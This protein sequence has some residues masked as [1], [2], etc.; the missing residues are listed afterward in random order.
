MTLTVG[1]KKD[2]EAD[3]I[4]QDNN[5]NKKLEFQAIIEKRGQGKIRERARE[6]ERSN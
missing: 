2:R 5:N 4:V 1:Y 3:V 6:R